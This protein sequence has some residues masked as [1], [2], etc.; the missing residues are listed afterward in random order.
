MPPTAGWTFRFCIVLLGL[1]N[2][3]FVTVWQLLSIFFCSNIKVEFL[4]WFLLRNLA[5]VLISF[6]EKNSSKHG[7]IGGLSSGH[8]E[9][10]Y[11][12]SS[13]SLSSL[14]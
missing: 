4:F 8:N 10:W 2:D 3:V 5:P 13:G 14:K 11:V 9:L 1:G 6:V 7:I 12:V